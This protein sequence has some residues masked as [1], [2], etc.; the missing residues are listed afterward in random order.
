MLFRSGQVR[1]LIEN[2]LTQVEARIAELQALSTRM[3]DA[4]N[5]WQG[6]PDCRLDDGRVCGLIDSFVGDDA[7]QQRN[8]G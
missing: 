8:T 5:E 6:A 4:M 2:R 7:E 1:T 3:R